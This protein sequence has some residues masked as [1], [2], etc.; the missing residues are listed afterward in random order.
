MNVVSSRTVHLDMT[1]V[2]PTVFNWPWRAVRQISILNS[3]TFE[4][5]MTLEVTD[6]PTAD[7]TLQRPGLSN[8]KKAVNLDDLLDAMPEGERPSRSYH[9]PKILQKLDIHRFYVSMNIDV[10]K[11]LPLSS[12]KKNKI[13]WVPRREARRILKHR[14]DEL[15]PITEDNADDID[16]VQFPSQPGTINASSGVSTTAAQIPQTIPVLQIIPVPEADQFVDSDGHPVPISICGDRTYDGMRLFVA[17]IY[18]ACQYDA[19]NLDDLTGITVHDVNV[20]GHAVRV[21]D[22]RNALRLFAHFDRNGSS[23]AMAVLEWCSRVMHTVQFGG[24]DAPRPEPMAAH[25]RTVAGR[26]CANPMADCTS[27]MLYLELMGDVATLGET[28]PELSSSV[29]ADGNAADYVVAKPGEG[30]GHRFGDNARAIIAVHAQAEPECYDFR[31]TLLDK[32]QRVSVEKA[33]SRAFATNMVLPN[34]TRRFAG[35]TEM[36]VLHKDALPCAWKFIQGE[37]AALEEDINASVGNAQVSDL[38]HQLE[39][40]QLKSTNVELKA[41]IREM[42][43]AVHALPPAAHARYNAVLQSCTSHDDE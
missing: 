39:I 13:V 18:S 16:G 26:R 41:T 1:Q 33:F 31:P 30:S 10:N 35:D 11:S 27:K 43:I 34:P 37:V 42:Q 17:H 29:P 24:Q 22:F 14:A 40:S 36:Y 19:A 5:A 2:T 12:L 25:M 6:I 8:F 23:F 15:L 20:D 32:R 21:V 7:Q 9:R 3:R 28:W 38:K 4:K